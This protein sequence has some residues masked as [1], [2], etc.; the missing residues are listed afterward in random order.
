MTGVDIASSVGI[1][2]FTSTISSVIEPEV[3]WWRQAGWRALPIILPDANSLLAAWQRNFI[4]G[5][6]ANFALN[7]L[8]VDW[9]FEVDKAK[10]YGNPKAFADAENRLHIWHGCQELLWFRPDAERIFSSYVRGL[11]DNQQVAKEMNRVGAR[12]SDWDF[13]RDSMRAWI[14]PTELIVLANRDIITQDQFN[15]YAQYY[16]GYTSDVIGYYNQLRKAIPGISDLTTMAVREAF[17][18]AI[19]G[20]LGQY[21][22]RPDVLE[23]YFKWLGLGWKIGLNIADSKGNQREADWLDMVWAAH[24]QAISPTQAYTMHWRYRPSQL[25]RYRDLGL[26]VNEFTLKDVQRHLRISDYPKGVRDYLTGI[27]YNPLRLVDIRNAYIYNVQGADRSWVN[28]R[29]LDRGLHPEDAEIATRLVEETKKR[30]EQLDP[31]QIAKQ[32]ARKWLKAMDDGIR[33]GTVTVQEEQGELIRMGLEPGIIANCTAAARVDL[34]N[35]LTKEI[36]RAI[37]HEYLHGG[38]TDADVDRMLTNAGINAET[39]LLYRQGWA[40]QLTLTRKE[41]SANQIVRWYRKGLLHRDVAL[42]RLER[43]GF[44]SADRAL[45]LAEAEQEIAEAL[46]KEQQAALKAEQAQAKE[47][48]RLQREIAAMKARNEARLRRLTPVS[49][50][51]RL[52]QEGRMSDEA[53]VNRMEAMD[54]DRESSELWLE[55]IGHPLSQTNGQASPPEGETTK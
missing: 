2:V 51:K 28:E 8:G 45:L 10:D 11:V 22:E 17:S 18:P 25:K 9:P 37:R 39:R 48:E 6:Q 4:N 33:L 50:L 1:G 14:P 21:D 29:F 24:W 20:P 38:L 43:L 52:V 12:K 5:D 16:G 53:F 44:A 54:Y 13:M 41:A 7:S 23:K 32:C 35:R 36:L 49:L 15:Q 34:A 30:R 27:A 42:V 26:D 46:L 40:A 47:I 3:A 55:S 31:A 19:A